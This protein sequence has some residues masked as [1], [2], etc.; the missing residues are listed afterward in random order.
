MKNKQQYPLM[1]KAT[2]IWLVDNTSLTFK[3]IATFCGLHE[4]EVKGIAD[5]EVASG[6]NGVDP[7][8][9]GQLDKDNL[10]YCMKNPDSSL[11]L[12]ISKSYEE[13]NKK[14]KKRSKYVPIARRQDKPDAIYWLLKNYENIQ[15]STIVKLIGTTKATIATIRDRSYW[16]M[17]N[18]RQRDPVLLGLCSQVDLDHAV[19]VMKLRSAKDDSNKEIDP[20]LSENESDKE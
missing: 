10:E 3:Q 6:I 5:G 13:A 7:I 8:V 19:E 16:N 15:D 14:A 4:L 17:K 18:I 20:S 12:K 2:A 11:V 9:G 1:P